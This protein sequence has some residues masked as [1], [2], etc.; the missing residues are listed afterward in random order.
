MTI[1]ASE[2]EYTNYE[3]FENAF[4]N[5]KE[6]TVINLD[7]LLTKRD[8]SV[9]SEQIQVACGLTRTVLEED[10]ESVEVL[11][12]MSGN[13]DFAISVDDFNYIVSRPHTPELQAY[14]W[15][16]FACESTTARNQLVEYV[17]C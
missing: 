9:L 10:N 1:R 14:I 4:K 12:P 17:Y 8:F 15:N 7:N 13:A 5:H 6:P 3:C 16:T 2:R 11:M